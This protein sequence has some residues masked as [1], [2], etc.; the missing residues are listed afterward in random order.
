VRRHGAG[1]HRATVRR[2]P[3]FVIMV[4]GLVPG[5]TLAALRDWVPR[6]AERGDVSVVSLGPNRASLGARTVAV[7][8]RWSHPFRFP[9]AIGYVVRMAAA[10]LR[11][12]HRGGAATI[13]LPQD[14]LATGA[15]AVLASL[16]GGSRVV[17]M[18]HG[19]AAAVRTD[20]F[21]RERTPDGLVPA[22][23]GSLLRGMLGVLHR[24]VLRRMDVAL[25]AGAEEVAG[26]RSRGVDDARLLGYRFGIDLDLFHPPSGAERAAARRRWGVENARVIVTVGRLGPEK[27]LDDLL[28]AVGGLR[29]DL[30][31][32][33]LVAGDGPLR[34][35]LE[36]TA[37]ATGIPVT[38]VGGLERRDVA[39]ILHAA[40]CFAYAARRGANTPFAVLEAMS[41]GLAV[42]ATAAPAAHRAMLADGRGIA[43]D[44]GD[45]RALRAGI[46]RYLRD[47]QSAAAAGAAARHYVEAHHAPAA[48]D[49]A[50]EALLRRL[51][52][53]G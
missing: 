1:E 53:A 51:G 29:D 23:R 14:A 6:L 40:D 25:L 43:I 48:V 41:S 22:V 30:A 3:R 45:R 36:R 37:A 39:S 34:D 11:E 4:W 27:G 38:F 2:R 49:E 18:E 28:A 9:N 16:V 10:A 15:A 33:L 46:E 44:A 7:G 52:L 35:E 26:Y 20:R 5:G 21:W 19:S 50:V 47:Q 8:A 17:V 24:V 13:L 32:R 31:P 12:G 42:V